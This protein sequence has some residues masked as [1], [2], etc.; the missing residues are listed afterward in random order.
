LNTSGFLFERDNQAAKPVFLPVEGWLIGKRPLR[1]AV[2]YA[3]NAQAF[4][5]R[6]YR[7]L[8][9][10]VAALA[11]LVTAVGSREL[12]IRILHVPLRGVSRDRLDLLGEEYFDYVLRP[13]LNPAAAQQVRELVRA[14]DC[15]VLVSR[16]LEH[17]VRPLAQFLGVQSLL[18]NRLEFRDDLAT[19]RLQDPVILKTLSSWD[20]SPNSRGPFVQTP[21]RGQDAA[22]PLN[23]GLSEEIKRCLRPRHSDIEITRLLQPTARRVRPKQ[24]TIVSFGRRALPLQTF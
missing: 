21:T 24:A 19:G 7:L 8:G 12:A 18:V 22:A 3:L 2:H 5:E 14:G 9:V 6:A 17:I 16:E 23:D 20:H 4:S 10:G 13:R 11:R 15:L 1:I